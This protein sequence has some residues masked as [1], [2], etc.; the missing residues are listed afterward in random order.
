MNNL[1]EGHI[2][3]QAEQTNEDNKQASTQTELGP[4]ANAG[5]QFPDLGLKEDETQAQVKEGSDVAPTVALSDTAK[6][7]LK[8]PYYKD[9]LIKFLEEK[10]ALLEDVF[11]AQSL[12]NAK[13]SQLEDLSLPSELKTVSPNYSV[14]KQKVYFSDRLNALLIVKVEFTH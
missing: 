11:E 6:D 2:R 9:R 14:S 12:R 5:T 10:T 4:P 1:T 13:N 8:D 3:N 7:R